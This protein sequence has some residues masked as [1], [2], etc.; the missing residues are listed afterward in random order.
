MYDFVGQ[1]ARAQA[2]TNGFVKQLLE[3]K[4]NNYWDLHVMRTLDI[5]QNDQSTGNDW[6]YDKN[7][8]VVADPP[9]FT[10]V[11]S[12]EKRFRGSGRLES[13]AVNPAEEISYYITLDFDHQWGLVNR[14]QTISV[15]GAIW[16]Q[17]RASR[18]AK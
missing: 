11:P 18:T 12:F 17:A 2:Y 13:L 5:E 9:V 8:I 10:H 16:R 6:S 15:M 1:G 4:M 7:K 3:E 14:L